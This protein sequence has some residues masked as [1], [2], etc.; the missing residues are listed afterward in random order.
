VDDIAENHIKVLCELTH[1]KSKSS[2]CTTFAITKKFRGHIFDTQQKADSSNTSPYLR[3]IV[4]ELN[5]NQ[6]AM[7]EI[8]YDYFGVGAFV[9][10]VLRVF[11]SNYDHFSFQLIPKKK[12]L[13]GGLTQIND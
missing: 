2:P 8:G 6:S 12:S 9:A 5:K 4:E 1:V 11:A 13:F 10:E 7:F 3:S